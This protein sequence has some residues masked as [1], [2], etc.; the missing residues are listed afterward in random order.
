MDTYEQIVER[1]KQY[2]LQTY[3]RYPLTLVSGKGI[4]TSCFRRT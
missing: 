4:S 3:A 1:E 2:L